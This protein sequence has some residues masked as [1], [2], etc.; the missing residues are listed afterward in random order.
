K[1]DSKD[2]I[3]KIQEFGVV[4][5]GGA[6]FP[7]NVKLSPPP[8]KKAEFLI[9]NAAECEPY[10][11]SDYRVILEMPEQILIGASI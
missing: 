4:G 6:T 3:A 2:I 10:L 1:L 11:T 5:L 7:T 8:G 9:I